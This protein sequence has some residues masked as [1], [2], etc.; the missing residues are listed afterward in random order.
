M[1]G[2]WA[3][4]VGVTGAIRGT[5]LEEG[6]RPVAYYSLPQVPFFPHA[7]IV[8]RSDAS[9]AGPIREAVR[10]TNAS[11]PIFDYASME[12][13]IR[14]IF[15]RRAGEIWPVSVRTDRS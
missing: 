2:D 4:I 1:Y 6:S 14:R 11:V 15:P 7:A 9:A 13:R 3:R 10:R 8:A 12:E 5:T